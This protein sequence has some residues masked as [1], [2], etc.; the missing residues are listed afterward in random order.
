MR[1]E[2]SASLRGRLDV[3]PDQLNLFPREIERGLFAGGGGLL[4]FR[5]GLAVLRL[6]L[7]GSKLRAVQ[8]MPAGTKLQLS[9]VNELVKPMR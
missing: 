2:R 8:H 5:L 6:L 4:L 1:S 3:L 9:E 7:F